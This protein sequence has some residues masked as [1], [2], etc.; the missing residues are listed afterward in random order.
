MPYESQVV[1]YSD[2]FF[3]FLVKAAMGLS[4]LPSGKGIHGMTIRTSFGL[5]VVLYMLLHFYPCVFW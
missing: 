2:F 1:P 5:D 3:S 4:C